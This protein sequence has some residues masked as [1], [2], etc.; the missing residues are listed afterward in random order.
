MFEFWLNIFIRLFVIGLLVFANAF[1]VISEFALV[2]VRKTRIQ[3]LCKE[4]NE[5]ARLVSRELEHIPKFIAAVQLGV[6]MSSLGLGWV[7]ES[8]LA[9]LFFPLFDFLPKTGQLI[10]THT[11]AA[12]LAFVLIT[13]LH[14]EFGELIPKSVSLQYP[15]NFALIVA[16]PMNLIMKIF[17]PFIVFLNGLGNIILGIFKIPPAKGIHLVHSI[18]E[19][20]MLVSASYQEGILNE[21]EREMLHNVF[22]FSDLITRQIMIPRPDMVCISTEISLDELILFIQEHQITRYPVYEND[23]DHIKGIVHIKD[24]FQYIEKKENFELDKIIRNAILVPETLTIDKLLI[25][26]KKYHGQM[27]IVIDEFGGT[28]GLVTLE[29]L[30]EEIFGDVQ[31]EFD[32]DEADVK[33][34]NDNEFIINAMLRI[35]EVNEL[36]NLD[37]SEEEIETIGGLVLKELGR[38]AE[39]N[40]SITIGKYI[41]S[42]ESI[43]GARI[44]S[45]KVKRQ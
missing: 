4:G 22:K 42:V 6:T 9:D 7:G 24:I 45:L 5:S 40:D 15:E 37:I 16:K 10:T 39:V 35:D 43:D 8:T 25:E 2:S 18:E 28:A 14:V 27:A 38:I 1:F 23:L 44:M 12:G 33:V 11:F 17:T 32:V 21:T 34:I 3:Q 13:I 31:D 26:F 20:D 41:F 29:D 30:L 19:L 36:F